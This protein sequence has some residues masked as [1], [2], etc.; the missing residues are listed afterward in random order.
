MDLMSQ[1]LLAVGGIFAAIVVATLSRLLADDAKA[2]LPRIKDN[3]IERAVARLPIDQ[4][5]RYREE[6]SSHVDDVPG[7]LSRLFVAA[8]FLRASKRIFDLGRPANGS[9]SPKFWERLV[10]GLAIVFLAPT[11][12]IVAAAIRIESKGPVF[13]ISIRVA[14]SGRET[15]SLRFRT[16]LCR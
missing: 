5:E 14:K 6:W 10:A 2:W 3:L 9:E 8:G 12:V 4:R 16:S 11:I 13:Y 7:E 1:G 15:R